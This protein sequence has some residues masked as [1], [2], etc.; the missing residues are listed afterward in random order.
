MIEVRLFQFIADTYIVIFLIAT[1]ASALVNLKTAFKG[2]GW[3]VCFV[4]ST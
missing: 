3:F 1:V 4:F 2:S